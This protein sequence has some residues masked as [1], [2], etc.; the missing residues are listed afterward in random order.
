MISKEENERLT[1]VGPG[2]P[3]GEM[4]RRYWWPIAFSDELKGKRPK[5]VRLLGEDFVVFR[6]GSGRV[7]M[8]EPQCAHRRVSLERGRVE[9]DG[10]RC[11]FHGWLWNADGRCLEQPCE[12]P[13]STFKDKV[14]LRAYPVQEAGGLVFV[15]IGPKPAPLLPKYDLLVHAE[16]MRYVWGLTDYC[17]WLQSAEQAIDIPHLS[18]LHAGPYPMYAGK[19]PKLEMHR[20]DYGI[21]YSLEVPGVPGKNVGSFVFPAH[22]RFTSG[23][24]EQAIGAR[25]NLLFRTPADDTYTMN[26]F[27]VFYPTE[28]GK[29][30]QKLET[31]PE[32]AERGPWIPTEHGV[33]PEGDEEWW[34]VESMQQDRMALESQG[35]IFDRSTEHLGASDRGVIMFREMLQ[36]SIKAVAE[37]RDPIGIVRDP[38]KNKVVEFGAYLHTFAP[39]LR[40]LAEVAAE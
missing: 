8:L 3:G 9:Q 34:G 2:T 17:N 35:L 38:A 16:G 39:P 10:I 7:G 31:P 23:R 1:R 11:C 27:I 29:L 20:R 32:L 5:K 13:E 24:V 37:G 30:V 40:P 12:A 4:L 22:N 25:H 6:D 33:Y 18:W 28:D 36:E 21:N 19:R 15:Y 26:F 14:S